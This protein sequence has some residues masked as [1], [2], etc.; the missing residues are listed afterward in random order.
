M[1][2][3]RDTDE[4]DLERAGDVLGIGRDVAPDP[5]APRREDSGRRRRA[6]DI[7]ERANTDRDP[8]GGPEAPPGLHVED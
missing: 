2:N 6:D 7:A 5:A 8:V 3:H 4:R 1:A